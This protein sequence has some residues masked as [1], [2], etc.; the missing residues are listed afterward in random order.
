VTPAEWLGLSLLLV[1]ISLT[2]VLLVAL[3]ALA[4][5]SRAARSADRLFELLCRELPATLDALKD[6]GR[7]LSDLSD[8]MTDGLRSAG[9]VVRQVDEGLGD[10]RR[11]VAIAERTSRS[12]VAG[13]AAGLSTLVTGRTARRRPRRETPL[14]AVSEFYD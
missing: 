13:L 5:L 14:P 6:T 1:A 3:P 4:E 9:A 11:N 7:E 10:V 12:L 8:E 2:L